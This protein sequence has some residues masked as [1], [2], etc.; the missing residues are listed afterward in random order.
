MID[1][2]DNNYNLLLS[3]GDVYLIYLYVLPSSNYVVGDDRSYDNKLLL[4]LLK[5]LY[6][7][8]KSFTL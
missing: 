5:S 1:L 6:Y 8:F 2:L 7:T 3:K 4:S